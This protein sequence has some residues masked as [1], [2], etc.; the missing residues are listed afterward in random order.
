MKTCVGCDKPVKPYHNH[1][2]WDCMVE[3]AKKAGGKVHCPNGLP[4]CSVDCN[5]D[6]WEH[7]HADHPD[8][9]FPVEVTYVGS[10]PDEEFGFTDAEG[11]AVD[12]GEG[13]VESMKTQTHALVYCDG[14]VALTLY[15][16]CYALWH[17]SRDGKLLHDSTLWKRG[18]WRLTEA[19]V[20]KIID[21]RPKEKTT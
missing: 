7:P 20:A 6:M 8:Y 21:H 3:Q 4:I 1:C 11:N 15:E 10:K 2:S 17:V 16:C 9:M 13:I 18:D 14:N 5:G 12:P 19:S